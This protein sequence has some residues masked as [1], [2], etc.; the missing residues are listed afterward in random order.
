MNKNGP[1]RILIAD[2]EWYVSHLLARYLTSE[3]YLCRVVSNGEAALKLLEV[4]HCDLIMADIIMGG[5]SG[6][7]LLSIV[8]RVYQNT[9]VVMV[10]SIDDRDTG[11][12]A[13]ELGA[14]GYII[15]PF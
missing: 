11:I 15:K 12:L 7:D 9:A 5:M 1:A 3:G 10:T 8:N 2:D 6:I 4:Y 13:I 14:Y